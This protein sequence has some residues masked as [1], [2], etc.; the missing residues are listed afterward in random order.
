LSKLKQ[1]CFAGVAEHR[2]EVEAEAVDAE[3]VAPVGQRV[4]DQVLRD[5]VAR[6]VV[7]AD[8]GVVP[9]ILQSRSGV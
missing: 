8:A 7:A 1:P 3:R 6:V 9:G 4:D 2:G 5:R